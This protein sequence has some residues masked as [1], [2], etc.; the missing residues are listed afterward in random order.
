MPVKYN[1]DL[2]A[3]RRL[4]G[5]L[6]GELDGLS[7]SKPRLVLAFHDLWSLLRDTRI[8]LFFLNPQHSMFEKL[9]DEQRDGMT[10][11]VVAH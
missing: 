9:S 11:A 2:E 3:A 7:V 4:V 1:Q 5:A 10:K 6:F 8:E